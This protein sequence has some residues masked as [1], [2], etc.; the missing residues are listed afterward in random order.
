[1]HPHMHVV[2]KSKLWIYWVLPQI[3]GRAADTQSGRNK[4]R[5]PTEQAGV[6]QPAEMWIGDVRPH[7]NIAFHLDAQDGSVTEIQKTVSV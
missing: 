2:R 3:F 4:V 1:M 7:R 6:I 5:G